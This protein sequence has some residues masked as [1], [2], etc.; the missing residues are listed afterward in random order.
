MKKSKLFTAL[1]ISA[2]FAVSAQINQT[3]V[4]TGGGQ[5]QT[6]KEKSQPATGSMYLN[7]RYMP[8]KVSNND[9][10]VLVRYNA[11]ADHF[12]VNNP[13]TE[14]E[15]ILPKQSDV[16]V[17][18]V[19]TGDS[20]TL[21]SY[22]AKNDEEIFGYL[23]VI[24]DEKNVKIYKRE[25]IHLQPESF[26][27]NSYQSYKPANYSKSDDE[28]YIK[29]KD[30]EPVYFSKKKDLAKMFPSKSKEVSTYIKKNKIDLENEKDLSQLALFLDTML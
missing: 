2:T 23:K 16:K 28:F 4:H 30:N 5:I 27:A 17:T 13:Q 1:L 11:Y 19:S 24:N 21:H 15:Q 6:S 7:E 29:I 10:N 9:N 25:R 22:K 14:T 12:Q 20:Y 18:F 8:A 26:P 3:P